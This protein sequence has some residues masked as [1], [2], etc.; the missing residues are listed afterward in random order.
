[1]ADKAAYYLQNMS[2]IH[3]SLIKEPRG[4]RNML[5]SILTDPVE[6]GSAFGVLFIHAFGLFD[7]CGDSTFATAAA[8]IETGLV[9]PVEPV[10][11][12][13]MDTVLGP[14]N[15]EADVENGV[16]KEVRFENVPS[17]DVGRVKLNVPELGA[18]NLDVGFGGQYHGFVDADSLGIKVD[19]NNESALVAA[20]NQIWANGGK[21]I[22]LRDPENGNSI[23]LNLVS[24]IAKGEEPNCYFVAHVYPPGRMGRTPGGTGTSALMGL[25]ASRG[26][27]DPTQK[28]SMK[29]VLGLAFTGTGTPLSL[30][31]GSKA[32]RPKLGTK[33]YM[34]GIQHF[35][36]DPED[37]F[38]HGFVLEG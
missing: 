29:S 27:Y 26:Q 9:T 6:E 16:V 1:M 31:N 5:G 10:T 35:V 14:L 12:F 33:S 22:D 4:H 3:E 32:V 25:L 37:P 28:F 8:A 24:F 15:I 36:I 23:T 11:R 13:V 38:K 17:Y 30:P 19:R 7:S 34:M 20:A 18:V 21:N 2:W